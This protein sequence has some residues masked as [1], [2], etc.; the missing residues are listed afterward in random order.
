M[1]KGL[2]RRNRNLREEHRGTR[3]NEEKI[4]KKR[5]RQQRSRRMLDGRGCV[6]VVAE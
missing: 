2:W 3:V 5:R 4:G 6:E 1:S